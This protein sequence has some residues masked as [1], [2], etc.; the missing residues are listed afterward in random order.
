MSA[1]YIAPEWRF[2]R[3]LAALGAGSPI[4]FTDYAEVFG[5]DEDETIRIFEDAAGF[6]GIC[7]MVVRDPVLH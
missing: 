7:L 5:I 2:A 4:D 1:A 3:A 6:L